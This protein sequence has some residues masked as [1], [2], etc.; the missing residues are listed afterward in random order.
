MKLRTEQKVYRLLQDIAITNQNL[1][2]HFQENHNILDL[3]DSINSIDERDQCKIEIMLAEIKRDAKILKRRLSFIMDEAY[4]I[5]L[6]ENVPAKLEKDFLTLLKDAKRY[7][8][9]WQG[10]YTVMDS[11]LAKLLC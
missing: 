2:R 10:Y 7:N 11:Y 3:L 8:N 1:A 9:K 6:N 4:N 5:G